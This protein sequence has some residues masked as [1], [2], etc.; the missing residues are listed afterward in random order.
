MH[1]FKYLHFPHAGAINDTLNAP[2]TL[3][4]LKQKHMLLDLL[5]RWLRAHLKQAAGL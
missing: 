3:N 5:S 2:T 1:T 4:P